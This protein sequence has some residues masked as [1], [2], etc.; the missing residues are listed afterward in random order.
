MG[1]KEDPDFT[2]R[3]MVVQA[4][5][6]RCVDHG[7]EGPGGQQDRAQAAGNAA[8]RLRAL[9]HPRR[10]RHHHRPDQGRYRR[11]RTSRT[12]SIR[13]AR[14]SA[15]STT[16]CPKACS[17]PISTMNSATPIITLYSLTGAGYTYPE[18]KNYAIQARDMLLG[19]PGVERPS[20]SAISRRRSSSTSRPKRWPSAG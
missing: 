4:C 20:S 11:A 6:A 12:P 1:Q 17:D 10:Q 8:S 18:L 7:N 16:S 9:L 2:F 3:V 15:I 14:R 5:L 13:C 19:T